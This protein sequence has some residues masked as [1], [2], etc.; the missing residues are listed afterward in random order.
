MDVFD[1]L[2]GWVDW[3]LLGLRLATGGVFFAH[4]IPKVLD[5]GAVVADSGKPQMAPLF[6]LIGVAECSGGLALA[7]GFLTPLAAAGLVLLSIAA[8]G[9]N[10]LVL[11]APFTSHAPRVGGWDILV[12]LLGGAGLI[13]FAGPGRFAVDRLVFSP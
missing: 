6:R 4:G 5:P 2:R 3:A 13:L 11:R 1:G 7:S 8:V 10:V 12:S 9:V